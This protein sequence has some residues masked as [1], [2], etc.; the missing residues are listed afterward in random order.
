MSELKMQ[1]IVQ[2]AVTN[3]IRVPMLEFTFPNGQSLTV[4]FTPEQA[5]V[6]AE[7]LIQ[8]AKNCQS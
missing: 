1:A 3:G 5:L 7:Q 8:A 6:V 4:G 2:T